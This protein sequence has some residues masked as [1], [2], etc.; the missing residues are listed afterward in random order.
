MTLTTVSKAWL[1]VEISVLKTS[2]V[3]FLNK[4]CS[5]GALYYTLVILS[6]HFKQWYETLTLNDK[7]YKV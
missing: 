3:L 5:L 2:W 7:K 4:Y 6:S 1:V